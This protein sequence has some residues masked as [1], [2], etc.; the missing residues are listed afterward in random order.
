MGENENGK[1]PF[2]W[3]SMY[4]GPVRSHATGGLR[5]GWVRVLLFFQY[6]PFF[7]L[8]SGSVRE[9]LFVNDFRGLAFDQR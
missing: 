3:N 1:G 4:R 5:G 9:R 7:L 8:I 6:Y 2:V